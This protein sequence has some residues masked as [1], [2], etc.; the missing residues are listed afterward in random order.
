MI[1]RKSQTQKNGFT[2]CQICIGESNLMISSDCPVKTIAKKSLVKI[3]NDIK[4]YIKIHPEF[5]ESFKPIKVRKNAPAIIKKMSRASISADVGPMAAVAGAIAE[6]LG[7][8]LGKHVSELIIENGGDIFVK[9][10]RQ[11]VVGIWCQ[12]KK[13]R[14]NLGILLNKKRGHCAICTSSGTLGHSFNYGKADAATVIAKDAALADAWATRLG[15]E[16][17][18]A[19]DIKRAVSLLSAV[20]GLIGGVVIHRKTIAVWGNIKLTQI[21]G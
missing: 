17:K 16:I 14:N 11:I 18:N 20:K 10:K 2:T 19:K 21:T 1:Y 3:R 13:I 5:S 4:N 9:V 15:N 8:N 6:E 7:E 12:N